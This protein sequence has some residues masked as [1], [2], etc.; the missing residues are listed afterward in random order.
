MKNTSN[1]KPARAS[2]ALIVPVA[3]VLAAGLGGCVY[4]PPYGYAPAPAYGLRRPTAMPMGR[5]TTR[6]HR[7]RWASASA[8]A[9]DIGTDTDPG[10]FR[11]VAN[12]NTPCCA[13]SGNRRKRNM[14]EQTVRLLAQ[15]AHCEHFMLPE[16][17]WVPNNRHLPVL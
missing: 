9:T 10:V 3:L 4:A 6:R 15:D 5:G 16:N 11:P 7:Y 17:G 8:A 12:W 2:R 1:P 13:F 14:T